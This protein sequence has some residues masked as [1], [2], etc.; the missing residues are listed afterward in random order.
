[1]LA[2]ILAV[3]GGAYA[4]STG[5]GAISVCVHHAGGGLYH[6][7]SCARHDWK[8][9]WNARGQRGPTGRTGPIGPIGPL[10][11][12]G[13]GAKVF[14]F[15]STT[16]QVSNNPS[17]A[18][19]AT[20]GPVTFTVACYKAFSNLYSELRI[21]NSVPLVDDGLRVNNSNAMVFSEP[22]SLTDSP[23]ANQDLEHAF[24]SAGQYATTSATE[25][26]I[27]TSSGSVFVSTTITS[28]FN[29]NRCHISLTAIPAA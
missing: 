22:F 21:T 23:G 17:Y 28:T 19:L 27:S 25:S 11:P 18:K 7:R 6:A 9:S 13:P 4:A 20:I 1:L 12:Q 15:D 5:G 10:G 24:T 8:L 14:T 16:P 3:G 29:S 2:L 26:L